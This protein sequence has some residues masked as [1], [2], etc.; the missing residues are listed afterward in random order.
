MLPSAD[1]DPTGCQRR[2]LPEHA[3]A[4]GACRTAVASN[5]HGARRAGKR[6]R[7]GNQR[8]NAVIEFTLVVPFLLLVMTGMASFGF[9]LHNDLILTNAV[10]TG[11]Q[12]LAFSRGQTND[13]CATAYSA[14]SSAAPSLTSSLS[15][16]FVINGN[17]YSSTTSCPS[18]ASGM[19]QGA[20]AQITGTY[21]CV[22]AVVGQKFSSCTLQSQVAEV[23]Q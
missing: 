20:S 4:T 14:I 7:F 13:P 6:S 23:I 8:G 10:N 22:L 17:T 2:P 1:Y 16:S 12:Q 5:G 18:A 11:A 3:A 21:P 9:A 19:V 15:L